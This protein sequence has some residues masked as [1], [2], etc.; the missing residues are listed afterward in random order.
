MACRLRSLPCGG[1]AGFELS[2]GLHAEAGVTPLQDSGLTGRTP[3]A[4]V[5]V[6]CSTQPVRIEL[7]AVWAGAVSRQKL[8]HRAALPM[9]NALVLR[10]RLLCAKAL[11]RPSLAAHLTAVHVSGHRGALTILPTALCVALWLGGDRRNRAF[12]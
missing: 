12:K 1:L 8:Q 2:Q 7:P 10:Q 5:D 3:T 9:R 4:I 11:A 6:R